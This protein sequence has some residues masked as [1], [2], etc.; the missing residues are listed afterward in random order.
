MPVSK[1]W[2]IGW[3]FKTQRNPFYSFYSKEKSRL[4]QP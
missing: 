4:G 3:G 1:Q 2:R